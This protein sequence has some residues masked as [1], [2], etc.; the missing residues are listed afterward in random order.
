MIMTEKEKPMGIKREGDEYIISVGKARV[1][2]EGLGGLLTFLGFV[3]FL[4]VALLA[5][6]F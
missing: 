2:C 1:I 6:I 4:M 3:V 5:A